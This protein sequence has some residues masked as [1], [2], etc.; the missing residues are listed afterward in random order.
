MPQTF[1]PFAEVT[2]AQIHG[3]LCAT[4]ASNGATVRMVECIFSNNSITASGSNSAV[5][6]VNAVNP[7]SWTAQNQDTIVYLEDCTF[8]RSNSPSDF[9]LTNEESD[10]FSSY[11]ALVFSS[12]DLEVLHVSTN[13]QIR[14]P[15]YSEL[16]SEAPLARKGLMSNSSW[17]QGIQVRS[18]GPLSLLMFKTVPKVCLK[19][20]FTCKVMIY[21]IYRYSGILLYISRGPNHDL[22]TCAYETKMPTHP[23]LYLDFL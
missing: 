15:G 9:I 17:L 3:G 7:S 20:H 4:W 13:G 16:P 22:A 23:R 10:M 8:T 2:I 18:F 11:S 14:T 12:S 1:I 6:S 19:K 5:L 21:R